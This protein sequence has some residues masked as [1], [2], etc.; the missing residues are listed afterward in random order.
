MKGDI[1]HH[2]GGWPSALRLIRRPRSG[3]VSAEV[4]E[5]QAR[6]AQDQP[7]EGSA[8]GRGMPKDSLWVRS[9]MIVWVEATGGRG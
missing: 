5:N 7:P 3:S 6:A 4:R 2:T 8:G 9:T 1:R